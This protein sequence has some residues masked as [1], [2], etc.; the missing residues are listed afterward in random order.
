MQT[1]KNNIIFNEI[2]AENELHYRQFAC[3]KHVINIVKKVKTKEVAF[4]QISMI[5]PE[6]FQYPDIC[7]ARI[8]YKDI[9][10][11]K[12]IF[13][14]TR[15]I[16]KETFPLQNSQQGIIDVFYNEEMPDAE[17]GPFLHSERKL[18]KHVSVLLKQFINRVEIFENTT[19]DI[20]G[21]NT[22]QAERLDLYR[23]TN[24]LINSD[25]SIEQSLNKICRILPDSWEHADYAFAKI[26]F[27]NKDYCSLNEEVNEDN[28]IKIIEHKSN[29][30]DK[31]PITVMFCYLKGF[32]KKNKSYFEKEKKL[33]I[34][35]SVLIAG[36]IDIVASSEIT[37]VANEYIEKIKVEN[38][39]RKK[40]LNCIKKATKILKAD[41]PV[42]ETLQNIVNILPEAWQYPQHTTAKILFNKKNY[43]SNNFES[44][45]WF[46]KQTFETSGEK[47]EVTVFYTK[48]FPE[49]FEGPFLEEE[50]DLINN[51]SSLTATYLEIKKSYEKVDST[52]ETMA[53]I[54][55]EQ[56]ERLKELACINKTTK[57]LKREKNTKIALQKIVDILP[58]SWQ[59]PEI[60]EA[61]ITFD[62]KQ[63]K[64][65]NFKVSPW[66]QRQFIQTIDGKKGQI[67]VYYTERK[68]ELFEGPF[69]KEE[70]NLIDNM[71][72][73][74]TNYLNKKTG[75][76]F[77]QQYG[78]DKQINKRINETRNALSDK[79]KLL[80]SFLEKNN[81]N[82]DIFHDLMPFKVQEI[83][84]IA[85]L[86]DAYSIESEGKFSDYILGDYYKLNLTAV[87]R[88]TGVSS[89]EES[90][91]KLHSKHFD[92]V[93][94][95]VGL[96]KK[97]PLKISKQI[98]EEFSH[99]PIY[100]LLNN[101]SDIEFFE[102]EK[103][104]ENNFENIFVWNGDSRIFFTMVKLLEDKVNLRN[105]T[106]IGYSRVILL[107]ED[108]AQ[109]Y[110]RYLP[111][112]YENVLEQT[113][114]VIEDVSTA[115][116]LYKVLRLRV[117]PKIILVSNF[118]EAIKIYDQYKDFFLSLISDVKFYKNG[119]LT[120]NAGF[121]LVKY[122]N[123][124]GRNFPIIMQSSE[125][126]NEHKAKELG[127]SFI[128]KHSETLTLDI[129]SAIKYNMGFGDFIYKDKNENELGVKASDLREFEHRLK[130]IP[131]DS[132]VYH[133]SND[134]FSLWLRARGEIQVAKK[135]APIKISRFK[136][137]E[138]LRSFLV[139]EIQKL[140][141]E[142]NKGK[143][144]DF[145]EDEL[146]EEST[147]VSLSSGSLGG[148]GRGLSF[149]HTLIYNFDLSKYF[150]NINIKAPITYIIETDEY[151]K[152]VSKNNLHQ[153]FDIKI[154]HKEIKKKFIEAK[155]YSGLEQK[156]RMLLTYT[157]KPLAVRSSGLFEDS[158]MQPF[159]GIFETYIIP[160]NSNNFELR[161]SQLLNAVKL[162][163]A[164]VFSDVAKAY[165]GA[166]NYKIEEE[167]MAVIIQEIVGNKY[168][169]VYY[170]HISGTAQ[171]Y[172]YYPYGKIEPEDGS[173]VIAVGLGTYVVE[174]EKAYRF[175][176]KHP[177]LQNNSPKDMFKNSQTE[178]FAVDLSD[179]NHNIFE[180]DTEGLIRLDIYDAEQHGTLKHC[181]STYDPN[182]DLISAGTDKL[183]PRIIN[184]ANILQYNYIPLSETIS[185]LLKT[186]QE[187]MGSP[188][189]IEF[190]VD[191]N[192]DKNGNASFY[193][194][195]VKPLIGNDTDYDIDIKSIDYEKAILIS[196]NAMGN[197]K[198]N[199]IR[200]IIFVD[201]ETFDKS[202]TDI[203]AS[204]I[205]EL[206][207]KMIEEGR[208]YVLIGPGRWG[209]RDKWIGIPVNWTN[210]SKAKIIV[211]TSLENFPLEASAG[212]HFF[213]NVTSMNVGYLSI[214]HTSKEGFIKWDFLKSKQPIEQTK[215]VK[216]IRLDKNMSIQTDGK[217]RLSVISLE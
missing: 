206:N 119:V 115:D 103:E 61:R 212:S 154:P 175:S 203:I 71:S 186:M 193:I 192:K 75:E 29:S 98:T 116:E 184:F 163:Y 182:N 42:E 87:P 199:N 24:N 127:A 3:L 97:A 216:H 2:A 25:Y 12:D 183:G 37:I 91:E 17:E 18:I 66:R 198:I 64:T 94:M 52:K 125:K 210:I 56:T 165:I 13:N 167:K 67:E 195:Q 140:K 170:P 215:Y 181:A 177:T 126:N 166:I 173:S 196:D 85:N 14:E 179:K 106:K 123:D 108:R 200:D 4:K 132:L 78:K 178:F 77:L 11:C 40:E 33:L 155:F 149:I 174:G 48:E 90:F 141:Y 197:G 57:I 158:L 89:F 124:Q 168:G 205:N 86:Y 217:K 92:L 144:V 63:Y 6:G 156:I 129:R 68:P 102:K 83:L 109:Y 146:L 8:K 21:F 134:H 137:P 161:V 107:A 62:G 20:E 95:M 142:K 55:N 202:Q 50:R 120:K 189:E 111:L 211:E 96:D 28:I 7:T 214:Q 43:Y 84:L 104:K 1:D 41:N 171:S 138:E 72:D 26:I 36:I 176:P 191:L 99:I 207:N 76:Q 53:K 185:E 31:R 147:I 151:D 69:L 118:E 5:L 32:P 9:S 153:Y 136:D 187:A 22:N 58:E 80:S 121:D 162:V 114:R 82:R 139:T 208:E 160:N 59:F 81:Y 19:K 35:L 46:Q 117:R 150:K 44:S 23:K 34:N 172:N 157:K 131:L 133:A 100:L 70:R 201:P 145:V 16:L 45:K 88:I 209:T 79:K 65:T 164:S 148:K 213:H 51:I 30:I 39:E 47:G 60:T 38:I 54:I 101:N 93:I 135:I 10:Y 204:E 188:V 169:N 73:I 112:L 143:I 159:A 122:I 49:L 27:D 190:A 130:T 152:F 110:S 15:W 194:L 113:R 128:H 105:D 180:S 74:I